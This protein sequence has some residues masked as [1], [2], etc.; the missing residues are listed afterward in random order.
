MEPKLELFGNGRN[1]DD[2]SGLRPALVLTDILL[3]G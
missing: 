2:M 1:G 3:V